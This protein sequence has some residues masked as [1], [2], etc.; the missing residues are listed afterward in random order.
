[1]IYKTIIIKCDNNKKL[2]NYLIN[3]WNNLAVILYILYFILMSNYGIK[4]KYQNNKN[5]NNTTNN[6]TQKPC[7]EKE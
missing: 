5:N 1:M 7:S 3:M 4:V 6:D 2:L